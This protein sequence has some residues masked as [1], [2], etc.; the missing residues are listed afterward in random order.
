MRLPEGYIFNPCHQWIWFSSPDQLAVSTLPL[1]MRRKEGLHF[2]TGKKVESNPKS[3][4][5]EKSVISV[6]F[7]PCDN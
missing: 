6:S 7:D 2:K 1:E 4:T 5:G 3:V